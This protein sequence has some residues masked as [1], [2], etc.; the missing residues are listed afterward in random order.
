MGVLMKKLI[1]SAAIVPLLSFAAY[2]AD[3]PNTKGPPTFAPPPPPEF[4]WTG[5]Y[6]G[7]DGGGGWGH[8]SS[9][10]SGFS[11]VGFTP[12]VPP[13][14]ATSHSLGGGFGGITGG[15]N[16]QTGPFVLG[17]EDS[18]NGSF[19]NGDS[20]CNP[21]F[22]GAAFGATS[23]TCND[24]LEY[25]GTL[26]GR[27]GYTI[28]PTLLLYVKGGGATGRYD[29]SFTTIAAGIPGPAGSH[30]I[31]RYGFTVGAGL[32]WA[33]GNNWSIKA[34]YDYLDFGRL[35]TAYPYVNVPPYPPGTFTTYMPTREYV[36]I[37]EL[38]V[39]YKFDL[40]APPAPVVAKY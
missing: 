23:G 2:A 18:F 28:M 35:T 29:Y 26:T 7:V 21:A 33:L 13:I 40:F 30:S 31:E 17:F 38:G 9:Y 5:F 8:T 36:N 11:F 3:L 37:V 16:W 14:P 34:E 20:L 32:E 6:V 12:V 19:I 4:S 24:R 15:Y 10:E 27:L 39:N 25:F 22:V 1:L